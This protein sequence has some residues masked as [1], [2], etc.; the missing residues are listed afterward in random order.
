M[1]L[2][3]GSLNT[4]KSVSLQADASLMRGHVLVACA[5]PLLLS[6]K[7]TVNERHRKC[8]THLYI[9]NIPLS[10]SVNKSL[11]IQLSEF[12]NRDLVWLNTRFS[13]ASLLTIFLRRNCNI[14]KF[15][16]LLITPRY[17]TLLG[18]QFFQVSL[19]GTYYKICN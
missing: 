7:W 9:W 19:S 11:H 16:T 3:N 18:T 5:L 17:G 13:K 1:G 12:Q 15:S 6:G 2:I 8:R 14:L 10:E 4:V